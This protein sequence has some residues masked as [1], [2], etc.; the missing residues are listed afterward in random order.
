MDNIMSGIDPIRALG[1]MQMGKMTSKRD[2][3]K[4][5]V[6][7]FVSQIMGD[8]F[9]GQSSMFGTDGALSSYTED[10][11]NEIMLAKVSQE[12]AENKAFGFDKLLQADKAW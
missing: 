5:F 6:G 3:E 4:E 9:K 12:I 7:I 8:V 11:Y 2:V 1:G 10:L